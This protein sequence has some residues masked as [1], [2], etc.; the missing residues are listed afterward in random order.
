VVIVAEAVKIYSSFSSPIDR[1]LPIVIKNGVTP[2]GVVWYPLNWPIAFLLNESLYR[3]WILAVDFGFSIWFCRSSSIMVNVLFQ[4]IDWH[5]FD[6][7][8]WQNVSVTWFGFAAFVYFPLLF[9]SVLS[10]LPLGWSATLN[11]AHFQDAIYGHENDL[12]HFIGYALIAIPWVL[13]VA[14]RIRSPARK[15]GQILTS[16]C[17]DAWTQTRN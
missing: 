6:T 14:S 16:L 9:V 13:V 3:V 10:K 5:W 12:Q 8:T 11:D 2:Y 1:F 17:V 15:R 4:L 7:G